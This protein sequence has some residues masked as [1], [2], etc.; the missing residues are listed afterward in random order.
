[1]YGRTGERQFQGFSAIRFISNSA[2]DK[3]FFGAVWYGLDTGGRS[4]TIWRTT[5]RSEALTAIPV[6]QEE[7]S[8]DGWRGGFLQ[9][10][11]MNLPG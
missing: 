11:I 4:P 6:V 8:G 3:G 7:R 5:R 2:F 1:M 10:C 9:G